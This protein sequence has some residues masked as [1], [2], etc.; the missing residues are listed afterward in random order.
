MPNSIENYVPQSNLKKL[1]QKTIGMWVLAL[2]L[3]IIWGSLI[4]AAPLLEA[5]N[6]K[7]F[8]E[9]IYSFFSYIC[10]QM[11][12][13]SMHFDQ[14]ALAVCSR[15]FGIYAGLIFGLIIYPFFRSIDDIEP[16]P[17]VWL[18]LALIPM[19]VD[20]TLGVFGIWDNTHLSRFVTGL[21]VGAACAVYIMPALAELVWLAALRK[22]AAK[23]V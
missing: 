2:S 15:C 17:K 19:A 13:R 9:P 8:S 11:P 4:L 22:I 7:N 16:L 6:F 21:I 3:T 1:R 18:F 20:W 23:R 14:H 10:H 5:A 12:S